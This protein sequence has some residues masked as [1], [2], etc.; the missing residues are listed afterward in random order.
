MAFAAVAAF[1]RVICSVVVN[2]P[3]LVRNISNPV[4]V[5]VNFP[6]LLIVYSFVLPSVG[7]SISKALGD[8][9]LCNL[10]GPPF[11]VLFP[12]LTAVNTVLG[13][14]FCLI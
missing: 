6:V 13:L 2:C 5:R 12:M 11:L 14:T 7:M 4:D 10:T 1:P 8:D 3:V 9:R